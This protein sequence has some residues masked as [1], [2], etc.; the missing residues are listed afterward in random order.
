[1]NKLL[2]R[3]FAIP[4]FFTAHY[5]MVI[6]GCSNFREFLILG[7]FTKIRIREFSFFFSSANLQIL[8]AGF[9]NWQIFPL[10]EIRENKNLM[11]I[12]RSTVLY[13]Y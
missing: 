6:F 11:N 1:M 3:I 2:V 10:R 7:L 13:I 5:S 8:F 4:K 12:T 9:L